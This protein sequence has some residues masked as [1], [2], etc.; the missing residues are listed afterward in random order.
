[1]P[2]S[3]TPPPN[4]HS[5][6]INMIVK[7]ESHVIEKTLSML[8]EKLPVSYWV[9]SDT[10]STDGTQDVICKFFA[11]RGIPGELVQHEWRDF[12][13][14]RTMAL[15]AAFNKTDF[16]FIF[17]ADDWLHGTPDLSMLKKIAPSHS[18]SPFVDMYFLKFG[19]GMLYRRPLLINNR[20][21]WQFRGVLHEYLAADGWQINP[22]KV[23]DVTGDYYVE[24]GKTGDRSK[25]PKKYDK[26]AAVLERGYREEPDSQL[27][28]RYAFYCAQSYKDGK[29][30]EESIE[31]YKKVL[32]ASNWNQEKYY[33]CLMIA[34]Q[35][36]DQEEAVKYLDLAEKY[37]SER[38]EHLVRLMDIY[39][40]RG[41][42]TVVN[43]LYLKGRDRKLSGEKLFVAEW[44]YDN[45]LE[46]YNLVSAYYIGD[47]QTGYSCCKK[48]IKEGIR[49]PEI[50][51]ATIQN[52]KY[53][54]PEY[55]ND[56]DS[57]KLGLF[58]LVN[59]KI[60]NTKDAHL[61][62]LLNMYD[63]VKP[64][65][66]VETPFKPN[67][68]PNVKYPTIMLTMTCGKRANLFV[69]TVNSILNQWTDVD[70]IDYWFCVDDNS[71]ANDRVEMRTKYPF[72]DFYFKTE[73]ERG[74]IQSMNIIWKRLN[75]LKPKYWIHMEDDFVFFD[76]MN[77][78]TKAIEGLNGLAALNVK[79]ILFNRAYAET[80]A[81]Y[82]IR[83]FSPIQDKPEFCLHDYR[84]GE[85]FPYPNAQYWPH[86]SF[87]PSLIDTESILAIGDYECDKGKFFEMEYALK[88]VQR[89]FKSAFFNK[90]TC[91]HIGRL[92]T[93]RNV[94]EASARSAYELN[95]ISQF[96]GRDKSLTPLTPALNPSLTPCIKIINLERRPDRRQAMSK[97]LTDFCIE[98]SKFEFIKAVD[99]QELKSTDEIRRLFNDNDFGN[100]RGFIGCALSHYYLWKRLV[101]DENND[102]YL[103]LEDD[104]KFTAVPKIDPS[105]DIVFYGY[106]MFS[107]EREKKSKED[108]SRSPGLYPLD[109]NRYIGGFFAYS[110]NKRGAQSLLDYIDQHGIK[111]GIDYLIKKHRGDYY[112]AYPPVAFTEWNEGGKKID[113]DIQN[114]SDALN[115]NLTDTNTNINLPEEQFV[116]IP[117]V[118]QHNNDIFYKKCSIPEMMEIALAN[119]AILSFNTLG[120]FKNR[121]E[122]SEF[123]TS[124]YFGPSDGLY[125]KIKPPMPQIQTP[126][127]STLPINV[128]RPF[129]TIKPICNW[130]ST[131][132]LVKEWNRLTKGNGI[133]N[134]MK[135][136]DDLS[137][138]YYAIINKPMDANEQYDP[139]RTV[140]FQ[141]EPWCDQE[142]QRWGVKTWGEWSQPDEKKFL[143]VR[144]H[145]KVY[146][147][148]VW[149][150]EL[151]Y[152][153]LVKLDS[154]PL[155]TNGNIVS[156]ICSSKYFDPGHI[157]RIDFLKFLE[158][159]NDPEVKL[160]IYN[161][162]NQHG[163]KS[164]VGRADAKVD[165]A[166]AIVPY[167]YYFMCENNQE[168]NFITEK[169]WES[170]LTETL[171]FYWG[172]PNIDEWLDP[173]SY[174]KLNM[175]DFEESYN[176]MKRAFRDNLYEERLPYIRQEKERVLNYFSFMPTM[177]RIINKHMLTGLNLPRA[178]KRVCFIYSCNV[179]PA[180][181]YVLDILL[182]S[183][184]KFKTPLDLIVIVNTGAQLNVSKDQKLHVIEYSP[185]TN[186]YEPCCLRIMHQYATDNPD[187]VIL[188]LHTKGISYYNDP[189]M[190]K[191]S[192]DWTRFMLRYIVE[193]NGDMGDDFDTMGCNYTEKPVPHY[194]G[195]FWWA[196]AKYIASLPVYK[197]GDKMS[198][199]FWL[200]PQGPRCKV[201][202]NSM[203]NH[204]EME[205]P[206][207][208][209]A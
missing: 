122:H 148:A 107:S 15:R 170:L 92:T 189:V 70:R 79:Q 194:S 131:K 207:P 208:L 20:I 161:Y 96:D 192:L 13:W 185:L 136:T 10:G 141:M 204:Y 60:N 51:E 157:K 178:A 165:K 35:T 54:L 67:F 128:P 80:I 91:V 97:M 64:I 209:P 63:I 26:D 69:Q 168:K 50:L 162:D 74:H 176:V 1:M 179:E 113:S 21:K 160:H 124:P 24:S 163:F 132:D 82:K 9:I 188:Y 17:D 195:N 45:M 40:R 156:S 103:I 87:R 175:D 111:H 16:L 11:A 181:T 158:A 73:A 109:L 119:P 88:W 76:K 116:F 139:S 104:I 77:Y 129:I 142:W 4:Y 66:T 6:C 46:W 89:G 25:D 33:S 55:K 155:K 174:V 182:E 38:K 146:N 137:A 37:D 56:V 153:Q 106:S 68:K 203:I 133:W 199:E 190:F 186:L 98:Q 202:C 75:A 173:R 34:G 85:K 138:D 59:N 14:N 101:A 7:N 18:T 130:C 22:S 118:D 140:V 149:E 191:R 30:P 2:G 41:Y 48:V 126:Q 180:G 196:T 144:S 117:R 112:E 19:P 44:D 154:Y 193:S 187:S 32:P 201:L 198:A 27:R 58:W 110:V 145:E 71:S 3:Q 72:F 28:D 100:R 31:W 171:C 43:A 83:G 159:K 23:K 108:A 94:P 167:K 143:E 8:V 121:A 150:F 169:I 93:E 115:L 65:L 81:D 62:T 29:R 12:G 152:P 90:V 164:Y 127:T 102:F 53:Y 105:K 166:K 147:N 134:A 135:L 5:L 61:E 78:I 125:V 151:T 57:V 39:S 205:M 84:P 49:F 95:N 52:F 42:H 114:S 120:F 177:E 86:Y 123:T 197:L 184:N 200:K 36:K 183:V 172:C 206:L 99:G 47:L